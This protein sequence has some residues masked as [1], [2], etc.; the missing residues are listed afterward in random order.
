[1]VRISI[2][3]SAESLRGF[4]LVTISPLDEAAD[5]E[6]EALLSRTNWSSSF[7]SRIAGGLIL[8]SVES[9]G[10]DFSEILAA[11]LPSKILFVSG[12]FDRLATAGSSD[13]SSI[14]A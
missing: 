3:G 4:D 7:T 8:S 13:I 10:S 6:N 9:L 11:Q 5:E 12:S 14:L 2:H 1:L